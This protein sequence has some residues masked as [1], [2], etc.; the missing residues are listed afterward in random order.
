M[1]N[2]TN[3]GCTLSGVSVKNKRKINDISIKESNFQKY[4]ENEE[5]NLACE[6][7]LETSR[8]MAID[9]H[10]TREDYNRYRKDRAKMII[11]KTA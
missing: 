8:Y 9:S 4:R 10:S 2:H 3:L 5:S 6:A 1:R 7:M 11:L